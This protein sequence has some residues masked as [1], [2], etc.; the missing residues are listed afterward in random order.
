[1]RLPYRERFTLIINELGAGVAG[2]GERPAGGTAAR[3]S[4]ADRDRQPAEPARQRLADAAGA[5]RQLRQRDHR[6]REQ[7]AAGPAVHHRGGQHGDATPPPS[8]PNLRTTLHELP[9]FLEQL[10]PALAQLGA[11]VDA[12]EPVLDNLNAASGQLDRLFTDLPAVL[13]LGAAGDQVAR[14][15]V[16]HGQGGGRRRPRRRSRT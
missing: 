5:D 9:A 8:R 12:N 7:R 2:R 10:R 11:A 4:G 3:G 13:A 1:M 15:G 14:P 16:G 6:A